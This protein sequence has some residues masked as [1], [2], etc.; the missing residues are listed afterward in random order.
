MSNR[1]EHFRKTPMKKRKIFIGT[2]SFLWIYTH[3]YR[4]NKYSYTYINFYA[5]MYK[6]TV[7]RSVKRNR[8]IIK[9]LLQQHE[10]QLEIR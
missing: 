7:S 10:A 8:K 5:N 9:Q 4:Y 2:N 3:S 1:F 6:N